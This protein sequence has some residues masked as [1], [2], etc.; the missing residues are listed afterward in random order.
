MSD[1]F[2]G[3]LDTTRQKTF[4]KLAK[5]S[6]LGI[7]GGGTAIALQIGHRSSFDFDIFL[8]NPI[9][10][11]L[12]GK[13]RSAF[14]PGC[15]QTLNTTDQINL[16]TP[17]NVY[18]TI[19]YDTAKPLFPAVP[20]GSIKLMNLKDL[21]SNKART[22]G[23]RGKW[24]D[25]VDLYFLLKNKETTLE[26]VISLSEKRCGAEFPTRLFLEQLVYFED[27]EDYTINFTGKP[28]DPEEIKS[29][30]T[31]AVKSLKIV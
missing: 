30:L 27:I 9:G 18:I 19:F 1:L 28:V 24:R 20:T 13:I 15:T 17:E 6:S 16:I 26:E 14:G 5:L 8:N 10:E 29:F 25:Y 2:L 12:P 4:Q 21:A 31:T 22:I 7:L 23:F 3:T 11:N